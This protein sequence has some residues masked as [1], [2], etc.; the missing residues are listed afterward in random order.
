M[1]LIGVEERTEMAI[2]QLLEVDFPRPCGIHGVIIDGHDDTS[3]VL[4]YHRLAG[5]WRMRAWTA[6]VNIRP[7]GYWTVWMPLSGFNM[8]T[9]HGSNILSPRRE[10]SQCDQQRQRPDETC[11]SSKRRDR[12]LMCVM[13]PM[14]VIDLGQKLRYLLSRARSGQPGLTS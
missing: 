9:E 12:S 7:L 14:K 2:L 11:M 13:A 5:S 3:I 10:G 6:V 1:S 8:S 4:I